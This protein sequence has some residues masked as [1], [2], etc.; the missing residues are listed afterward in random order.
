M[1]VQKAQEFLQNNHRGVLTT[2][3]QDGSLQMSPIIIGVNAD[4][5]G[6]ISS[7]ETAYKVKNLRRD[8]RA[9]VCVF[10]DKFYGEWIQIDGTAEILSLP[11]AMEPLVDFYKRV[12]GEHP[13]WEDY[14]QAMVREKRVLTHIT[15]EQVGPDKYG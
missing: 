7:R 15:I 4:G 3:W 12:V 5:V 2:Y 13:D 14:R 11:E 9:S 6:I 1:D 10:V 8:P